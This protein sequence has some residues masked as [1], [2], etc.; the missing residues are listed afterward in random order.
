MRSCSSRGSLG[1]CSRSGVDERHSHVS[2]EGGVRELLALSEHGEVGLD[3]GSEVSNDEAGD[4]LRQ[5]RSTFVGVA[6]VF[7]FTARFFLGVS[8]SLG[9]AGSQSTTSGLCSFLFLLFLEI[10]EPTLVFVT[11]WLFPSNLV[12]PSPGRSNCGFLTFPKALI[13]LCAGAMEVVGSLDF[14]EL[15]ESGILISLLIEHTVIASKVAVVIHKVA[16]EKSPRKSRS[17]RRALTR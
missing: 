1:A 16:A 10:P 5:E 9:N 6:T 12:F 15:E 13:L 2:E 8:C 14:E 7:K 3:A 11:A 4:F 17:K